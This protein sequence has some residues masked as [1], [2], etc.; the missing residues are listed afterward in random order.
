[1]INVYMEWDLINFPEGKD[2]NGRE[3]HL[4]NGMAFNQRC[5]EKGNH[6][7]VKRIV[8]LLQQFNTS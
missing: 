6:K 7:N 5:K 4:S 2:F 1:M 3:I 8:Y